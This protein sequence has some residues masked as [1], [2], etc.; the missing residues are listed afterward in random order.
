MHPILNMLRPGDLVF[1][2]GA[3]IGNKTAM[4]RAAGARVVAVE[5]QPLCEAHLRQRFASD[6]DVVIVSN[7]VG[8]ATGPMRMAVC[9]KATTISSFAPHWQQSRFK[10]QGYRWPSTIMVH[11]LTLDELIA[12]YGVPKYTKIDVEGYEREVLAGLDQQAGNLSF[13]FN[14]DFPEHAETCLQ[15]LRLLGYTQFT[16]SWGE[17]DEFWCPAL[18][19]DEFT[20]EFRKLMADTRAWQWGDVYAFP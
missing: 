7:G 9:D 19:A 10:G 12:R 20:V 6:P 13:E 14:Q 5:P 15:R 11:M 3:H 1:D 17:R 2:I 4:Y 18:P 8:A 16:M